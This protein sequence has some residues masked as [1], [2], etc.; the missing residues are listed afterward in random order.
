MDIQEQARDLYARFIALHPNRRE[1]FNPTLENLQR[2]NWHVVEAARRPT[3]E[4]IVL[5]ESAAAVEIAQSRAFSQFGQMPTYMQAKY[6]ELAALF[7]GVQ[8]YACGSRVTG[9]YV[10]LFSGAS[11]RKM[12]A[13][14]NLPDKPES[15]YDICVD[16]P[17]DLAAMREALP[18]WADLLNHGVPD[19]EKIPIP[20]WDFSR[21]PKSE[22]SRVI[23][24]FKGQ[25][26]GELMAV[27]NRYVLSMN[28][29]CCDEKP[30]ILYFRW[31]IEKGL[32]G[33]GQV[34]I[35]ERILEGKPYRGA[36]D[37][38]EI[39]VGGRSEF[40]QWNRKAGCEFFS[41]SKDELVVAGGG[42]YKIDFTGTE[43]QTAEGRIFAYEIAAADAKVLGIKMRESKSFDYAPE[44]EKTAD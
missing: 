31:A 3:P 5:Q 40:Y 4:Q 26:W 42:P 36:I 41:I 30:I 27:H 35:R 1:E 7:P 32:I 17:A 28:M 43:Q 19:H 13:G 16:R 24:L 33:T 23:E 11:I 39:R 20:M 6:F 21:L 44:S 8:L 38:V 15:D 22:H 2:W 10:E 18:P 9:R 14:L 37:L 29:Y 25:K 12:R 34:I